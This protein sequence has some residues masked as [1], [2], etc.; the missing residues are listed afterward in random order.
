[1]NKIYILLL[2]CAAAVLSGCD[3]I[4]I[5]AAGKK[6]AQTDQE[7]SGQEEQY[8]AYWYY[9]YAAEQ[10]LTGERLGLGDKFTPY[11]LAHAGDTIFVSNAA[12]NTLLLVNGKTGQ[13]IRSLKSWTFKGQDKTFRS[14][15]EAIVPAGNRL[16]VTER[17]SRIH[18]FSLP[19]LNYLSC[20][21]NGSWGGP[22]FQAQA[23]AVAG[24]FVFARD[25]DSKV[26][27]YR[28]A[29]ATADNFEKVN[30]YR[31]AAGV[32]SANNGFETHGMVLDT[33]GFIWLTD[34]NK[35]KI[36]ALN[37]S[38]VNDE[39]KQNASI[40]V[41]EKSLDLPFKPKNLAL[42]GKRIL[43]T[44]DNNLI[45]LYD[46]EKKAWIKTIKGIG[47]Y[48]FVRPTCIHS[49]SDSVI[50]VSDMDNSKRTLV[51]MVIH[52]NEIREYE[53]Q[54]GS[55]IR[56]I[57]ARTRNGEEMDFTVDLDTHERID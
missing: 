57:H 41:P 31:Q 22:V 27:I 49:Q 20:I 43:A 2:L 14:R 17:E 6:P 26:S 28:E 55:L 48:T 45:N 25:K 36:R 52:K 15:I 35:K 18:V 50:W 37:P 54:T 39:M 4:D 8:T 19:E 29:D 51:K 44:G 3:R 9:S 38:L 47:G 23:T 32:Q 56:V 33:E 30:R 5:G 10:Q 40:D 42:N 21:G 13:V 12:D 1:M 46:G 34:F 11:A 16:Y 53:P 7:Q 24:G